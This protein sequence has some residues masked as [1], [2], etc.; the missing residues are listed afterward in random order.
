MKAY[1]VLKDEHRGRVTEGEVIEFCRDR[2][3]TYKAPRVVD[4]RDELP[5]SGTGKMLRRLLR[6]GSAGDRLTPGCP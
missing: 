5:V 3:T 4:F 2:L 6:E 1:V